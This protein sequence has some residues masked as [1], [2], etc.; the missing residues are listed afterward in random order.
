MLVWR[1]T[2]PELQDHLRSHV[3]SCLTPEERER[4]LAEPMKEARR[5]FAAC[6]REFGRLPGV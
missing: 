4:F 2:W 6:E 3:N 1:V 5:R